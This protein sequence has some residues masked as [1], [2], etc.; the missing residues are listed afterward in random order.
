MDGTVPRPLV[1]TS[2]H[3]Q[4]TK[5]VSPSVADPTH[6]DL[7]QGN[8]HDSTRQHHQHHGTLEHLQYVDTSC[9]CVVVLESKGTNL[10]G[11]WER[12]S[13]GGKST[14]RDEGLRVGLLLLL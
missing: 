3:L 5:L 2:A 10:Q 4:R 6:L 12:R 14:S 7:G 13:L 11:E 1:T 8:G 9:R